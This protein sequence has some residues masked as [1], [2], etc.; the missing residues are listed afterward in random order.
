LQVKKIGRKSYYQFT[1]SANNHY[2]KAAR[3][4]YAKNI[5]LSDDSWLILFPS[6]VEDSQLIDLKRQLKWL[7]FSNLSSG[8]YAHPK[9]DQKSIEE[10]LRELDIVDSVIIFSGQTIDK[11]SSKVLKKLVHQK[12]NI[13]ELQQAYDSFIDTY[14]PILK[15]CQKHRTPDDNESD[16]IENYALLRLLLIHE[17]RRILLQDHEL[18]SKMLP[19]DWSGFKANKLVKELYSMLAIK[20]CRYITTKLKAMD[21]LL[22]QPIDDFDKRF[23]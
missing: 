10:T 22:S 3:R 13:S 15:F 16:S 19:S 21:G 12:W 7:G 11:N 18:S 14:E 17:Y 23:R 9:F 6:F 4:I 20:S 2:T 1:V 5:C 8:A